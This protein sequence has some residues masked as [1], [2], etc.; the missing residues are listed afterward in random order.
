[1]NRGRIQKITEKYLV[2]A[3][4][5]TDAESKVFTRHNEGES[6]ILRVNRSSRKLKL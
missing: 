3:V 5:P 2:E 4:S 6:L 1:M